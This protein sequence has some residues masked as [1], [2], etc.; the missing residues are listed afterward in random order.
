MLIVV[1]VVQALLSSGLPEAELGVITPY[2][3]QIKTL[4]HAL[5]ALPAVEL[6]TADR[7]QGRDK[8]CIIMSMVRSNDRQQVHAPRSVPL[9]CH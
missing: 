3:Q 2:R 5:A 9:A 7:S 1:Q 6:L 8:E 4:Q